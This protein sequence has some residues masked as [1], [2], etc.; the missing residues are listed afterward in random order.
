MCSSDLVVMGVLAIDKW[1]DDP[2]GALSAHGLAGIWGTLACG[3]FTS[4]R[5]AETVGV[6]EAGLLQGGG[7]GQ[8]GTQA[9][10]VGL[11]FLVVFVLSSITFGLIKATIGIR[12]DDEAEEAG[13]DIAEHGM[14]GYPEQ[15]IPASELEGYG[16]APA[17]RSP[18]APPAVTT[19]EEVPAT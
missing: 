15:F 9:A 16:A 2:V 19:R 11:T 18:I 6:G 3:L 4:G 12:V 8:L 1:I 13:L 7:I 17:A 14:Y 10:A 5:L